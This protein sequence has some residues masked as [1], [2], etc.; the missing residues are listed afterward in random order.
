MSDKVFGLAL[1][2]GNTIAPL[3]PSFNTAWPPV[4][5]IFKKGEKTLL[6]T[7]INKNNRRRYIGVKIN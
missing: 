3:V 2:V 1:G 4:N 5:N 6:L 7:I